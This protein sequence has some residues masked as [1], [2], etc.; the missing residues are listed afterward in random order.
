[1]RRVIGLSIILASIWV[2]GLSSFRPARSLPHQAEAPPPNFKIAIFGDQGLENKDGAKPNEV[3]ELVKAE[4][5]KAILHLGDFDYDGSPAKW[6][7]QI[8]NAV[9][10]DF[11]YFAVMGNHDKSKWCSKPGSFEGYGER[12]RKRFERLNIP[13]NGSPGVQ[14]SFKYQG[15]FFVLVSPKDKVKCQPT[16]M[17]HD[18]YINAQLAGDSSIWSIAGWHR[19]QTAMQTGDKGNDTGWEVYE[20]A[21]KGGAI[22]GTGHE[23]AYARSYLLKDIQ[24]QLVDNTSD[25]LSIEKGKTFAFVSGLG[26]REIRKQ[27][28]TGPWWARVYAK[29][30]LSKKDPNCV[31]GPVPGVLFAIFNVDGQPNKALFY[32]KTIEGKELDRFT[33]I[34]IVE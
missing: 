24:N 4:G 18:A 32:F 34:S 26:G 22:V 31:A 29:T 17:K 21:R 28:K 10:A 33:V 30:C 9:G 15:I 27:T 14:Y 25:T 3:F 8:N 19:N 23:H 7:E 11:P 1:M 6:E 12:I 16:T 20:E 2:A 5:A 13:Y